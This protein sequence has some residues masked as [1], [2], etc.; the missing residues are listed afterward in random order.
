MQTAITTAKATLQMI[1]TGK[2]QQAVLVDII[3]FG[4]QNGLHAFRHGNAK[5]IHSLF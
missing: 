3:I 5:Q 2:N 4:I 1:L